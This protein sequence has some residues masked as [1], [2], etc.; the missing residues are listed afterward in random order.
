[1]SL[2]IGVRELREQLASYLESAVPIE[3]TRHG[4]TIGIYIPIPK[5]PGQSERDAMLEAGRRMQEELARLG[6]SEDDLVSDFKAWRAA[7]HAE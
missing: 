4:Q 1:M 3:V 7:G 5:R 2:R 6:V